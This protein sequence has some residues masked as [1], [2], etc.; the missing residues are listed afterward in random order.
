MLVRRLT[1][2]DAS[3]FK[4]L[5][6]AGLQAHPDA[7]GSSWEEEVAHPQSWFVDTLRGGYVAGCEA[8]ETLLGM[9]GFLRGDRL[10]TKH[11][12]TL[13]G[14]CVAPEARGLG[15]GAALVRQIIE[16]AKGMVEELNLTVAAHNE[17]A[18][19][20]YDRLGFVRSGLDP[21]ALKVGDRYVDEV[22]M[23][24]VL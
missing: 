7:F 16:E 18:L 22:L 19:K 8:H 20:L 2:A 5:R 21:H 17:A 3:A 13:W 14:M 1:E 24:L 12:G 15:V 23:R 4:A 6:L 11:R 9:A 10:K